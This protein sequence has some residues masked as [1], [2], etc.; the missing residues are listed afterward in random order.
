[1]R[2]RLS[3][4]RYAKTGTVRTVTVRL[5]QKAY[6]HARSLIEDRAVVLDDR[7]AWSEHEPSAEQE[8][9]YIEQ[10]G[11]PEYARWYLGVDDE[12]A[13]DTKGRYRFPYGDFDKIHRCAV[14]SAESRAAQQRYEDIKSAVAHLHGMLEALR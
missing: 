12:K 13:E 7:D 1:L 14:L 9:R 6:D 10:H 3:V 11:F 8:N 4:T 2:L 5:N